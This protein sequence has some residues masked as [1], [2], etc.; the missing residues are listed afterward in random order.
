M[1][2]NEN[3]KDLFIITEGAV[4]LNKREMGEIKLG[5]AD[6][7]GDLSRLNREVIDGTVTA[8]SDTKVMQIN[9]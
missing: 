2:E 4:S 7:F 8:L 1:T 5:V 9:Q 6:I 3:N